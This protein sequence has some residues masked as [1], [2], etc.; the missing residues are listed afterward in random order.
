MSTKAGCIGVRITNTK[1]FPGYY[2]VPMVYLSTVC[3]LLG[4]QVSPHFF[5]ENFYRTLNGHAESKIETFEIKSA[6]EFANVLTQI[7]EK[8]GRRI[9]LPQYQELSQRYVFDDGERLIHRQILR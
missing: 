3:S 4:K 2:A 1:T 9:I 8:I 7:K 5:A 6:E